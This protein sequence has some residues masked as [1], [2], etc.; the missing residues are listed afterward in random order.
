MFCFFDFEAFSKKSRC[1]VLQKAVAHTHHI[2]SHAVIV[3][4]TFVVLVYINKDSC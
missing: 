1:D 2:R 4:I 3:V